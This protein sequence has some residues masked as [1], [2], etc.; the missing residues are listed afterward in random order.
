[1][2]TSGINLVWI[3]FFYLKKK[4]HDNAPKILNVIIPLNQQLNS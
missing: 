4:P 2:K 1:M 3:G